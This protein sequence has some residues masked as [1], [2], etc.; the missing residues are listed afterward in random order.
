[1]SCGIKNKSQ[2]LLDDA[3]SCAKIYL[4]AEGSLIAALMKLDQENVHRDLDLRSL[5]ALAMSVLGLSEDVAGNFVA[6]AKKST[7]V[8]ALLTE[9]QS[10]RVS[11]SNARTL[12]PILTLENQLKWLSSACALSKR[13]LQ[14]EIAREYPRQ[15]PVEESMR[16][17]SAER[18]QLKCGVSEDLGNQIRRVQDLESSKQGKAVSIEGAIEAAI[19]HYLDRND[20]LEKAKRAQ[21]RAEKR[22]VPQGVSKDVPPER[23]DVPV[24]KDPHFVPAGLHH[25]M[26]LRDGDQ[27]TEILKNGSRC[28]ERRWLHGH[29]IIP[30]HLGGKTELSN[31]RTLCAFCHKRLHRLAGIPSFRNFNRVPFSA[32]QNTR[33]ATV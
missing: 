30:V 24:P 33:R 11:V 28:P 14:K 32:G 23:K 29:H 31:L 19:D 1:M 26:T 10:G 7:E 5:R 16:Y 17:V 4:S 9:I 27:C 18:L 6:I 22:N 21:R 15:A 3:I 12:L 25:A 2:I 8:P 13:K 20:P